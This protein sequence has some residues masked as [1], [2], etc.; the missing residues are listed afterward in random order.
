MA[1]KKGLLQLIQAALPEQAGWGGHV[2]EQFAF[3]M[4]LLL[5][6]PGPILWLHPA[7][8]RSWAQGSMWESPA[9]PCL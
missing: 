2:I 7:C 8:L 5:K 9:V 1:L 4:G 6:T 3:L